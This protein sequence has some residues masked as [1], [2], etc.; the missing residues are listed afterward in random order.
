MRHKLRIAIIVIIV[1]G[2]WGQALAVHAQD[3]DEGLALRFRRN[4]GY[5]LGG[6]MQ[7]TFTILA[8]GPQDLTR[9]EFLLDGSVIGQDSEAPFSL[10]FNTG[11]YE[12][13]IHRFS[14][15]GYRANGAQLESAIVSRQFV[16]TSAVTIVVIAIVALVLL[17]RLASY[18]LARRSGSKRAGYGFLGGAICPH[19]GRPFAFHWWSLRLGIARLDRCPH[20]RKWKMVQRATAEALA[21]AEDLEGQVGEVGQASEGQTEEETLRRRLEESRYEDPD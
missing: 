5:G 12:Q 10:S 18:W 4:F 16:A 20:C 14:A 1:L 19:C 8:E 9:V 2:A 11:D 15:V 13:G 7:G 17:F 6:Q 21:A 3:G